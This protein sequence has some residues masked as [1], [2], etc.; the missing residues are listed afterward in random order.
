MLPDQLSCNDLLKRSLNRNDILKKLFV[1]LGLLCFVFSTGQVFLSSF[2]LV[3]VAGLGK[4]TYPVSE[5]IQQE[6]YSLTSL[7][8]EQCIPRKLLLLQSD[9]I[10]NQ[11]ILCV[12]G[13]EA[14]K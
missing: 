8:V 2:Q 9:P 13:T 1:P 6:I 10:R 3:H 7:L 5:G 14:I 12:D 4:E 11:I